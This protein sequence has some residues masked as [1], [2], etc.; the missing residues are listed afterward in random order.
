MNAVPSVILSPLVCALR[1][2]RFELGPLGTVV[3]AQLA[4]QVRGHRQ[5]QTERRDMDKQYC[6]RPI[7]LQKAAH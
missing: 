5:A 4:R 3:G 1:S 7:C 6:P 2:G